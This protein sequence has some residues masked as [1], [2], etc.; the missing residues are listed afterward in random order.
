[1]SIG[2]VEGVVSLKPAKLP[3]KPS[4]KKLKADCWTLF[5]KYI[6]LR[7]CLKTTK[8]LDRG[9]CYTC[10][11]ELPFK[12]LQAG[13][14]VAGRHNGNLFSERG[15]HAQCAG[16]NIYKHSNP[17]VY[18]RQIIKDYGPGADEELE[19]E[20]AIVRKFTVEELQ[21]KIAYYKAE[22]KKLEG[23]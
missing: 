16:C 12:A 11:T 5:S 19:R 8:T 23:A 3:V 22:I 2:T 20:A 14:F 10:P 13:H 7:D 6:R 1:M 21:E 4:I 9:V 15:C 17:L 18:R